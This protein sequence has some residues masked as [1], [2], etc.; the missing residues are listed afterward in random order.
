MKG[1]HVFLF[2]LLVL[3][4]FGTVMGEGIYNQTYGND[5]PSLE[6]AKDM[7]IDISDS[8]HKDVLRNRTNNTHTVN[9]LGAISIFIIDVS[10][11]VTTG[12]IDYGYENTQTPEGR[13][14]LKLLLPLV[15]LYLALITKTVWMLLIGLLVIGIMHVRK[16]IKFKKNSKDKHER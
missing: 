8:Q 13:F 4:Y 6:E 3:F 2:V 15:L 11:E 10:T 1:T 7:F 9:V 14:K 16:T 5:G 12:G